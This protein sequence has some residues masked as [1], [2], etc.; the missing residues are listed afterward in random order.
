MFFNT[1][2][3]NQSLSQSF[4][5]FFSLELKNKIE[6]MSKFKQILFCYNMSPLTEYYFASKKT[7]MR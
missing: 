4:G 1:K 3:P 5:I 2:F 6:N 7:P